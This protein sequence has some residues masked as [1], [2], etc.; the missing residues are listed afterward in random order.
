[1]GNSEYQLAT[2]QLA[3][4]VWNG[5]KQNSMHESNCSANDVIALLA[6]GS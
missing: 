6:L 4:I 1:M 3:T 2:Y 5:A